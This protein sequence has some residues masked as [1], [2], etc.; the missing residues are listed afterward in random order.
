LVAAPERDRAKK[1]GAEVT[2]TVTIDGELARTGTVTFHPADKSGKI[3]VGRIYP[4]GSFS[5]RTGQGDLSESDGGTV[6]PG[7]YIVTVVVEGPSPAPT[8]PGGPPGAGPLL[9]A[10]RYIDRDTTDL[11][12]NIVAGE[13][14]LAFDL[15][16]AAPAEP[17]ESAEIETTETTDGAA[18]SPAPDGAEAATTEGSTPAPAEIDSATT[19]GAKP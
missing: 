6:A 17:A 16:R 19:E 7:E 13:N 14:V 9:I 11:R 10:Q 3:A 5:L 8:T 18:N 4:D 2:G 1:Y 12:S 15:E